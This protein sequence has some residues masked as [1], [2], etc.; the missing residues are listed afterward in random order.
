MNL[1]CSAN[2]YNSHL[3]QSCHLQSI[4]ELCLRRCLWPF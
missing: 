3:N 2:I 4:T 1:M